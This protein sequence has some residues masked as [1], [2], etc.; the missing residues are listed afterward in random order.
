MSP[1]ISKGSFERATPLLMSSSA[2]VLDNNS[3]I[4]QSADLAYPFRKPVIIEEIRWNLRM[5]TSSSQN[6]NL[7]SFVSTKLSIGQRY[8]MRDP[9]PIWLLGTLLSIDREQILENTLVEKS[10]FSDYRWRLPEPLYLDA[11][12]VLSSW[13][14]RG[15][16][17]FTGT[18]VTVQVSY[19]GRTVSPRQPRP[20]VIPIPYAASFVTTLGQ[21]YGQSNEK[22]LF[23]PFD[24]PLRVQR[25]TGRTVV[26]E[27]ALP[28]VAPAFTPVT[29]QSA[30]T[31]LIN[32]SWGGK[33]VGNNTGPADVFDLPRAA[34]TF[35]TMMPPKGIYEV[36]AWNIPASTQV[37]VGMIGVREEPL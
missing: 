27:T 20:K 14:T 30:V 33:I 16:D 8:L 34:W 6:R 37:H 3:A 17:S 32:D 31:L 11:G 23:N 7:G 5:A 2:S 9:V 4:P 10:Y 19:V 25:M 36:R 15:N 13:F 1:P 18:P 24:I 26:G 22:H 28:A 21:T 12:Q 29:P 35:D